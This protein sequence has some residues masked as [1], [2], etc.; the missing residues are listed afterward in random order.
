MV[1]ALP[2]LNLSA[3]GTAVTPSGDQ[4]CARGSDRIG[5]PK[6]FLPYGV[7]IIGDSAPNAMAGSAEEHRARHRRTGE[8]ARGAWMGTASEPDAWPVTCDLAGWAC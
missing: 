3:P 8:S 7:T 4:G 2:A 5:I 6:A 1:L